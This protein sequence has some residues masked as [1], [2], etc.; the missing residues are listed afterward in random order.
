MTAKILTQEECRRLFEYDSVSGILTNRVNRRMSKAGQE[1]GGIMETPAGK[2]YRHVSV[3]GRHLKVHRVIWLWMTGEWPQHEIDHDDGNGLNNSWPNLKAA[4][5]AQNSK[6]QRKS[7]KNTSG[8]TGVYFHPPSGK[9]RAGIRV[10]GKYL[11]L[12]YYSDKEGAI[13]ARIFSQKAMGFHPNHGAQ[14]PL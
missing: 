4:T 5:H 2:K 13:L 12:G 6:N 7:I 1:A 3:H 9:W 14:R 8:H 11:S 10:K